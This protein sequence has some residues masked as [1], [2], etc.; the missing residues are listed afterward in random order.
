MTVIELIREAFFTPG[1]IDVIA[2]EIYAYVE[3]NSKNNNKI[4]TDLINEVKTLESNIL[5]LMPR[6]LLSLILKK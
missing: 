5:M 1:N 4:V 3:N 6:K 2:N